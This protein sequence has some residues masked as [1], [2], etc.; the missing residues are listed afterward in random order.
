MQKF[1][2]I[3]IPITLTGILLIMAIATGLC[4]LK[5]LGL[6]SAAAY[7]STRSFSIV[8]FL[9]ILPLSLLL[10]MFTGFACLGIIVGVWIFYGI[11]VLVAKLV[12]KHFPKEGPDDAYRFENPDF[13]EDINNEENGDS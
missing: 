1:K 6:S 11:C 4:T 8:F 7:T 5:D 13:S 12:K 9:L 2:S 10:M 3:Y